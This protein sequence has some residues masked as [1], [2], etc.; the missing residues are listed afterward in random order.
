M[1]EKVRRKNL[2]IKFRQYFVFSYVIIYLQL[3][4]KIKLNDFLFIY[5]ENFIW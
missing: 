1:K 2:L 4:C 3:E 5:I